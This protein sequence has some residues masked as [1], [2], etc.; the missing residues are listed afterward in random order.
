M[1]VPRTT[2][3]LARSIPRVLSSTS[4]VRPFSVTSFWSG[5]DQLTNP[6]MGNPVVP[7]RA[8]PD[9]PKEEAGSLKDNK[10]SSSFLGTT[11]RLPEFQLNDKVVLVT[12]AARGLGL[13]QAEGLL[14]AGA[15]G[16]S[17]SCR[18]QDKK[19]S[20][21][22]KYSLCPGSATRAKSTILRDPKPRRQRAR[23]HAPLSPNRRA[24]CA[25]TEY[26]N[27]RYFHQGRAHGRSA[28]RRGYS[29][30][31]VCARIHTRR[32]EQHV[33]S[34]RHRC[35][36]DSTGGRKADDQARQWRKYGI[37]RQHEW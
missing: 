31:D 25:R 24:E 29:T 3:R 2:M 5:K 34:Q 28:G 35:F 19:S 37:H 8:P 14:E 22:D 33:C 10:E 1:T 26:D 20:L 7:D 36:D 13:T 32:R 18:T 9:P 6:P 15:T 27:R 17:A 21:A 23:N 30:R 11:K 16:K 12:G 4:H